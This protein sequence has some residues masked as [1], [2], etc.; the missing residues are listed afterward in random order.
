MNYFHSILLIFKLF[1][2]FIKPV[3]FP[4]AEYIEQKLIKVN[5]STF[6]YSQ[7]VNNSEFIKYLEL[8]SKTLPNNECSDRRIKF[9]EPY[10]CESLTYPP[11]KD[12]PVRCLTHSQAI[13]FC[14][15]LSDSYHKEKNK[16][17][18]NAKI[19][20]PSLIEFGEAIFVSNIGN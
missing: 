14:L 18:T 13:E 20:L 6:V 1:S 4:S 2:G 19:A 17:F 7:P 9:N 3:E 11:F 5:D 12:L 15:W 16:K 8:N 10:L